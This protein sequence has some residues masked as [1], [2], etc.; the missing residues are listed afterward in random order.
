MKNTA[1]VVDSTGSLSNELLKEP[2]I[3]QVNLT[4]TF[5]D[6]TIFTDTNDETKAI[7]FLNKMNSSSELPKT[8]QPE[9]A[10]F[11]EVLDDIKKQGYENVLFIHLASAI[12]GT[13]QTAQMIAKD[14]ADDFNSYFIDSKSSSFV[15]EDLAE[16][17]LV[18]LDK[19]V[20]LNTIVEK[21]QWAADQ[22]DVFLMVEN[23][24]NLAK[25][26]RLSKGEAL[27]GNLLSIKPILIINKDGYIEPYEK[28]RTTNRALKRMNKLIDQQMKRFDSNA[29][30]IFSHANCE[31]RALKQ[32]KA[33]QATYPD[34]T[35]RVGFI[36]MIISAHVGEG[37]LGVSVVPNVT[38]EF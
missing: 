27:V 38:H 7:E 5:A 14:Y 25:G 3:Y 10:Q 6:G 15:I 35:Y 2:Y 16:Q 20:P 37:A 18:L 24:N 17:A 22:A 26:G 19:G 32:V 9:P 31:K 8:S 21:L 28:V 33:L 30:I 12:S 36:T 23:L 4:A 34:T 29:K 13:F 11:V 1:I